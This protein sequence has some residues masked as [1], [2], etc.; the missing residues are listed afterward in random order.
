MAE[1]VNKLRQAVIRMEA[2][3]MAAGSGTWRSWRDMAMMRKAIL[4]LVERCLGKMRNAALHDGWDKWQVVA[5]G[6]NCMSSLHCRCL[7]KWQVVATGA[8]P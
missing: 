6:A 7:Y 3:Q 8:K 4:G 5:T 2:R 1:E